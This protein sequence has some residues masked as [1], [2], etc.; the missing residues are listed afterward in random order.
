[1]FFTSRSN[2]KPMLI[3]NVQSIKSNV[4]QRNVRERMQKQTRN[5]VVFHAPSVSTVLKKLIQKMKNNEESRSCNFY[6]HGYTC[7]NIMQILP[8]CVNAEAGSV[9][10]QDVLKIHN[11]SPI[12]SDV[13]HDFLEV[14]PD[15]VDLEITGFGSEK[16]T[17]R[18]QRRHSHVATRKPAVS[19]SKVCCRCGC[20]VVRA[21]NGT[22]LCNK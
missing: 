11:A 13:M 17:L 5:V 15:A 19:K 7:V 18:W 3:D 16:L 10:G 20:L 8:R 9:N 12:E 21:Q 4:T 22:S 2:Q 1:M 6:S 14:P